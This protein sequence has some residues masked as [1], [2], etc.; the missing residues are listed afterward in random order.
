MMDAALRARVDMLQW[1]P[2]TPAARRPTA[3]GGEGME[4]APAGSGIAG[5]NGEIYGPTSVILTDGWTDRTKPYGLLDVETSP[6]TFTLLSSRPSTW[7]ES[8]MVYPLNE[9]TGP[10]IVPRW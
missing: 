7:G 5:W 8:Q 4:D 9:I 6:W 1:F 2:E 10:I 3:G